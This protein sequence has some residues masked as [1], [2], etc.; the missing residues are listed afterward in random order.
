[1]LILLVWENTLRTGGPEEETRGSKLAS[2]KRETDATPERAA[3][4]GAGT[5]YGY[6]WACP[7]SD[8]LRS[9]VLSLGKENSLLS[10]QLLNLGV[11]AAEDIIHDSE[12]ATSLGGWT[13]ADTVEQ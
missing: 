10:H 3:S 6:T 2:G 5:A 1:M 12:V 9:L 7:P 13:D 4:Q 8:P 11:E